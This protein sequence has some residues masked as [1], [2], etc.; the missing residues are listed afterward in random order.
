AEVRVAREGVVDLVTGAA[1]AIVPAQ[2]QSRC[3]C[4]G[5]HPGDERC[6]AGGEE[7]DGH[8]LH[9]DLPWFRCSASAPARTSSVTRFRQAGGAPARRPTEM[10][11]RLRLVA[12]E[13]SEPQAHIE[14]AHGSYAGLVSCPPARLTVLPRLA[15]TARL[16]RRTAC[17][18]SLPAR[19]RLL[20]T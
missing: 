14:G 3:R 16:S 6:Q 17:R 12:R 5:G 8:S 7:D 10:V 1:R 20:P 9:G 4:G 13:S 18:P 19:S 11:A 15:Q 2:V